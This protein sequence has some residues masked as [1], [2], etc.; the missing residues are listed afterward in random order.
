MPRR[1]RAP[2]TALPCGSRSSCF[3]MTMTTILGIGSGSDRWRKETAPSLPSAAVAR[4]SLR[5]SVHTHS[6]DPY[7]RPW[8]PP[9]AASLTFREHPCATSS[10]ASSVAANR[11]VPYRNARPVCRHR[12]PHRSLRSLRPRPLHLSST[13]TPPRATR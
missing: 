10:S 6:L 8:A 12:P 2:A 7:S 3:G 9:P 11:T 5:M 4:G 13:S 1:E